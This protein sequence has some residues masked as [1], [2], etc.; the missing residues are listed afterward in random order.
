[1]CKK[2]ALILVFLI[3]LPVVVSLPYG[4]IDI[5]LEKDGYV[6]FEGTTDFNFT[7]GYSYTSKDGEFWTLNLSYEEKFSNLIY[8]IHLPEGVKVNY[9]KM[10]ELGRIEHANEEIRVIGTVEDNKPKIFLQYQLSR[11]KE[12]TIK[13]WAFLPFII[14]GLLLTIHLL[15]RKNKRVS[16]KALSERQDIIVEELKKGPK[17]QKELQ[18]KTSLPK[19]SLSRNLKILEQKG[20]IEIKQTGMSN[21]ISLKETFGE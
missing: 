2:L 13:T 12:E 3:S 14:A 6:S 7:D 11:K 10:P 19:S 5:Y 8:T 9:M 21:K 4:D 20:V 16:Y 18:S 17:T 1:M 15:H